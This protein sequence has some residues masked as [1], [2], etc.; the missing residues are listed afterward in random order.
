MIRLGTSGWSYDDWVG[1]V[2][3]PGLPKGGWLPFLADKVDTLEVNATYYRVPGTRMVQG[4]VDR[5]PDDFVFSVKAHR[6]LTHDRQQ[7]DFETFRAALQPLIEHGKLACVLAQF[8]FS[9]HATQG[10]ADYLRRVRAGFE[11]LPLVVEFRNREWFQPPTFELLR[12][13]QLGYCGVDEPRFDSLI[14]PVV[15]ATGPVG[16]VRFH[17]RN[18]EKWWQHDEAWERYDYTYSESELGEWVPKLKQ[19]EA[20]TEVTLAYANNHYRGQA[21]D[22]V[23]KLRSLL[24]QQQG[25]GS[26]SS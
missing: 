2:Y 11:D 24:D 17:G 4:W 26:K 25:E 9:F 6:S 7:P 21:L 22:T 10:N 16:Y 5:T 20:A 14:P 13:L 19:L 8:P 23:R 15:E 12:S 1:P 18:A 3:P